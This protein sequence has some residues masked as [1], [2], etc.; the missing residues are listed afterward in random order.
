MNNQIS[1][2]PISNGFLVAIF[3]RDNPQPTEFYVKDKKELL[4]TLT[5]VLALDVEEEETE[6][7]ED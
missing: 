2:R 7:E 3:T 1:I 5:E 6:D 4:N